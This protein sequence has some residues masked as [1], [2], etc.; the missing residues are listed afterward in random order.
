M[1]VLLV[2]IPVFKLTEECFVVRE[3]WNTVR[4]G[5]L[6][7]KVQQG[8]RFVKYFLGVNRWRVSE[9]KLGQGR[10]RHPCRRIEQT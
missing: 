8:V 4:G 2:R 7:P 9:P 6:G 1:L 3:G 5:N 10:G